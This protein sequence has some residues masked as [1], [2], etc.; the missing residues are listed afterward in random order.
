VFVPFTVTTNWLPPGVKPTCA[1][2]RGKDG[3]FKPHW[4]SAAGAPVKPENPAADAAEQ[5]SPEP[6]A[7]P[8]SID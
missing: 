8:G 5:V 3:G 7:G 6:V 1:G 4:K 2:E